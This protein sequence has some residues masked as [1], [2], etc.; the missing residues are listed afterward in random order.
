MFQQSFVFSGTVQAFFLTWKWNKDEMSFA[1]EMSCKSYVLS[2]HL[3][4]A[5][6]FFGQPK[7][8]YLYL[9]LFLTFHERKE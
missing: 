2:L 8:P 6:L 3:I 4:D 5:V 1:L 9:F 7:L